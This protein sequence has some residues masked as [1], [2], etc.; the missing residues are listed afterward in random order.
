MG[1]PASVARVKIANTSDVEPGA[2]KIVEAGGRT[3]ALFN[4]DGEFHAIDNGCAHHGGPLGEG[5]LE[6]TIV[7][8]PW[9]GY[10]Y[11]V[12]TGAHQLEASFSV[13]CYPVT[14]DGSAV[15]VDL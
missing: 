10:R 8:C 1:G 5:R 9:H 12:R 13:A 4:V 14:V 6:G 3:M 15:Y 11:D 7:T 2:G